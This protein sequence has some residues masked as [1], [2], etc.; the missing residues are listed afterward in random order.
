HF[1]VGAPLA[2]LELQIALPI[3]FARLPKL[4]LAEPPV[5]GN[6]YHFHGLERLMVR[7]D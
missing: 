3:L 1:C 6:V 5:Y 7:A 4:R 2:R